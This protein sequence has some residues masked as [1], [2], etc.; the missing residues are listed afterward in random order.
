MTSRYPRYFQHTDATF[1]VSEQNLHYRQQYVVRVGP[2]HRVEVEYD[3]GAREALDAFS[4]QDCDTYVREGSW[5]ELGHPP[6]P[7]PWTEAFM[8]AQVVKRL[9]GRPSNV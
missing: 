1:F 7:R 6:F 4:E 2:T 8:V 5:I 3:D 9:T